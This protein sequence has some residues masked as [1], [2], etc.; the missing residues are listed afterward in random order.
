[1][2]QHKKP[3]S[4]TYGYPHY[5][6]KIIMGRDAPGQTVSNQL[7]YFIL[8]LLF[9]SLIFFYIFQVTLKCKYI[10]IIIKNKMLQ[11][12]LFPVCQQNIASPISG[13]SPDYLSSR[14]L[15]RFHYLVTTPMV[16]LRIEPRSLTPSYIS[17]FF[18]LKRVLLI[19]QVAQQLKLGLNLWSSC[20]NL[21][22]S[23]HYRHV[24]LQPTDPFPSS[25]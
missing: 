20:L 25:S 7:F 14:T 13:W 9:Y 3:L 21:P 12:E 10:V 6:R 8:W 16:V 5:R 23:W 2:K 11:L 22:E 18:T 4:I 17:G 24:L 1:M 19:H 15:F